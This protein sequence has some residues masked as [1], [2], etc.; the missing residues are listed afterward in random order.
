MLVDQVKEPLVG[1]HDQLTLGA[2]KD[3]ADQDKEP[4]VH[5]KAVGARDN[6]VNQRLET[7]G[8]QSDETANSND[9]LTRRQY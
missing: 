4:N 1:D 8:S 5:H 2:D 6:Q 7:A 3:H 9:D